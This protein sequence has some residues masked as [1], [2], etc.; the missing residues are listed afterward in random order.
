LRHADTIGENIGTGLSRVR[1]R[2]DAVDK[3]SR[4]N[5][6]MPEW[7]ISVSWEPSESDEDENEEERGNDP[8]I[9]DTNND[10]PNNDPPPPPPPP[11]G[12]V[13]AISVS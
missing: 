6:D 7:W 2:L 11:P 8:I 4:P 3:K 12:Q 9:D 13:N 10:R 5:N 1:Y